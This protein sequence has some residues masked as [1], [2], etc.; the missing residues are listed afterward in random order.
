MTKEKIEVI[1]KEEG[2]T[3]SDADKIISECCDENLCSEI[4]VRIEILKILLK[5]AIGKE[6]SKKDILKRL[7]GLVD[8][9]KSEI[10]NKEKS[11]H[12]RGDR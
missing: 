4:C 5:K 8:I 10:E 9:V 1:L 2:I 6:K 12:K 7:D 3:D 11:N